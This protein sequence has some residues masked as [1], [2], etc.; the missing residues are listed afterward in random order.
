M[1]TICWYNEKVFTNFIKK[2]YT[3]NVTN[4]FKM[5]RIVL[6]SEWSDKYI[7]FTSYDRIGCSHLK[8]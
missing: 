1:H 7:S 8:Q 6:N 2:Y 3:Y 4:I 5:I